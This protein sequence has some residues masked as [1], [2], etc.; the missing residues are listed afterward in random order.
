LVR[1]LVP[2]SLF[3][4]YLVEKWKDEEKGARSCDMC[5]EAPEIWDTRV[6][7]FWGD[8]G[9]E[10]SV[11]AEGELHILGVCC[12]VIIVGSIRTPARTRNTLHT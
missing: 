3:R 10:L 8:L 9:L 5:T 2:A 1:L 6:G 4:Y 11:K 12:W 7:K